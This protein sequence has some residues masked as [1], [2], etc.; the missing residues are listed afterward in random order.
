MIYEL[1]GPSFLSAFCPSFLPSLFFFL[2]LFLCFIHFSLRLPF[3]FSVCKEKLDLKIILEARSK[4]G[5]ENFNKVESFRVD[6]ESA[7]TASSVS[8][9][10]Y[11]DAAT[12]AG[13]L[14]DLDENIRD[15][16]DVNQVQ[17]RRLVY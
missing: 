4:V 14:E 9:E 10:Y 8:V 2:F 5:Q 11:S 3:L 16:H 12:L 7:F 15:G 1:F 17:S 13:V 6:V